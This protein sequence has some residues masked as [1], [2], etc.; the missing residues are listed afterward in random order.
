MRLSGWWLHSNTL[1]TEA[2][3]LNPGILTPQSPPQS[4]TLCQP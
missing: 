2:E 1:E 3:K 4:H